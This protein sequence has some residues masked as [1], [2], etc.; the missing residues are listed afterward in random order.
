MSKKVVKLLPFEI[1][2]TTIKTARSVFKDTI[3]AE[4]EEDALKKYESKSNQLY[5]DG[6]GSIIRQCQEPDLLSEEITTEVEEVK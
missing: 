4:N 6:P 1:T 5:F 2:K 3:M